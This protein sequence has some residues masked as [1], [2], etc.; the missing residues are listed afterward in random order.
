MTEKSW[1][2]HT[3]KS[4]HLCLKLPYTLINKWSYHPNIR[5]SSMD[6]LFWMGQ[7]GFNLLCYQITVNII[8]ARLL[9]QKIL[10][11]PFEK[12]FSSSLVWTKLLLQ[13]INRLQPAQRNDFVCVYMFKIFKMIASAAITQKTLDISLPIRKSQ[14]QIKN[15]KMVLFKVFSIVTS[16]LI[17]NDCWCLVTLSERLNRFLVDFLYQLVPNCK[18]KALI[19]KLTIIS[20]CLIVQKA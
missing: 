3:V 7:M 5:I 20:L 16:M 9:K 19:V 8:D 10:S 2:F 1:N 13:F 11:H 4:T 12:L 18:N 17:V 6:K 14:R 15:Y